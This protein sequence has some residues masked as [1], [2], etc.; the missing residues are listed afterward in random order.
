M[1]KITNVFLR[2]VKTAPYKAAWF[3]T[4][5]GQDDR[6]PL[7]DGPYPNNL[8][9]AMQFAVQIHHPSLT[10]AEKVS[11]IELISARIMLAQQA[12]LIS[13]HYQKFKE[14]SSEYSKTIGEIR[15]LERKFIE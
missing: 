5:D 3:A 11:M 9:T 7:D 8:L 10:P 14:A 15:N 12:A 6:L 13:E 2:V 4:V 1:P